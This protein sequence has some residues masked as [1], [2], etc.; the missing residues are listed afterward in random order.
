MTGFPKAFTG[1]DGL[2]GPLNRML[3]NIK[4]RTPLEGEAI[5]WELTSNGFRP[6]VKIPAALQGGSMVE[7][8]MVTAVHR[9]HLECKFAAY[10]VEDGAW[11]TTGDVI[12][13]A[14]PEELRFKGWDTTGLGAIVDIDGHQYTY[15][16]GGTNPDGPQNPY[17]E[18]TDKLVDGS[19][20]GAQYV[21]TS[22]VIVP[23]YIAGRTIIYAAKLESAILSVVEVTPASGD[24][25]EVS[26]TY[27][28]D[29]I[30]LNVGGRHWAPGF[31][32]IRVCVSGQTGSWYV[33][34]RTS[35]A[36]QE[37]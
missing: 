35:E 22:Q 24:N 36:F 15:Q 32:K 1:D 25:P 30:D 19:E 33:L 9:D 12:R 31:R 14:K 6:V 37:T 29:R 26:N 2:V 27:N 3:Q 20:Y 21:N 18:R 11:G 4:E 34:I 7:Q 10:R 28:I 17:T 5:K 8:M 13:V 16:A 23:S